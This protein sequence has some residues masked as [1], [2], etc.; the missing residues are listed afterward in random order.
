MCYNESNHQNANWISIQI[1]QTQNGTC[2][3]NY[4]GFPTRQCF[5][6]SSNNPVGVWSQ[7]INSP[8][9]GIP[10]FFSF[11]FSPFSLPNYE[12]QLFD[13][14]FLSFMPQSAI[15]CSNETNYQNANW[16]SI[17]S[18]QTQNGICIDNYYGSPTRQC[19]QNDSNSAWSSTVNNPCHR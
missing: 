18:D 10:F 13:S 11:Y 3:D 2:I 12:F 14:F 6:N 8:C 17:Q 19:I 15:I 9:Q 5:Q 1:G 4:Y 7:S 16:I